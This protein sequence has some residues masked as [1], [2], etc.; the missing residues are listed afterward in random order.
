MKPEELLDAVRE[1]KA[2]ALKV[3]VLKS[4]GVEELPEKIK[5]SDWGALVD[6]VELHGPSAL[7][8]VVEGL[9]FEMQASER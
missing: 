4:L 8:S 6:L 9:R 7:D 1:K 3:Q 5:V 2:Y